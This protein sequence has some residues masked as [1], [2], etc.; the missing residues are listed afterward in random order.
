MSDP[1]MH[2]PLSIRDGRLFI[3]DCDTV[4]LAEKFG[5][6][7]FVVSE[8]LL[9]QNARNYQ[10]A[11]SK[12]WPEGRARIMAACKANPITAIR[13]VLTREGIGCDTFG[14]GELELALRGGVP[15]EDIAVNG[16][17]KNREII[18]KAIDLDIHIILDS[19]AEIP[20]CIE[21]AKA[22]GK[23]AQVLLRV[24]PFLDDLDLQSDFFPNRTIT[25]MTQTVKYGIPNSELLPMVPQIKESEWLDLVGVHTHSGRHSKQDAFWVSL[26]RNTVKV[27]KQIS[28]EYGDNWSPHIVSIGGG[29]AAEHD[30]ESRV[31][32]TDYPTP[33]VDRFAEV[34]CSAFRDAM[35]AAGLATEGL[36]LEAEPGRALHNETGIHLAKVHVTKHE[37]ATIDRKWAETDT[38]ECFL[39]I[40]SLNLECPFQYVFANRADEPRTGKADIAGITCNYEC[41]AENAPVPEG[42]APGDIL[43]FLNTGS[44]IEVYT[45]NFN[46][47]PRPGTVL[48]SGD[49]AE[50]V[51][52]PET[53][54]DVFQRDIVPERLEAV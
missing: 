21:E 7:L 53:L 2:Y 13:R 49:Q 18:R 38:S 32:V 10:A 35:N 6:P 25:D 8:A 26:V 15:T 12:H 42:M 28:D 19:P 29:F 48:V 45:C 43:A 36:I 33:S 54:D 17:I 1:L 31:A 30:L 27:I 47:L 46:A 51:K 5:T 3:E 16:S 40:G 23:K 20:Y 4:E 39:S 34:I 22:A 11:F 44:Y 9:V 41:L 24:K 52:R 14:P 37:S 50:W